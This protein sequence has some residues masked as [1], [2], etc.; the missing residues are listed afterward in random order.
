ML[1]M[2]RLKTE[3]ELGLV[4]LSDAWSG[5]VAGV[6]GSSIGSVSMR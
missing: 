4:E 5:T 6:S 2:C 3:S 1:K